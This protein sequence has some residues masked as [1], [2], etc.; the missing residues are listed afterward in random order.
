MRR[1]YFYCKPCQQVHEQG[2]CE[3]IEVDLLAPAIHAF[4]PYYDRT[5]RSMVYSERDK[6]K[7]MRSFKNESHPQGLYNVRDDKKF[8]KEMNYI[9]KHREE[10][11]AL[12]NPGYKPRTQAEIQKQGEIAHDPNR[13][14]IQRSG[15]RTFSYS[16]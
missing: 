8:L 11:K 9:Q 15:K 6:E 4:E 5:L 10:Y 12:T 14:D 13:H 7:K 2:L 3:N 16:R 1:V